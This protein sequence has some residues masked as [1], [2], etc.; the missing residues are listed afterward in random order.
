VLRTFL[1]SKFK[2][3]NSKFKIQKP[4][5]QLNKTT[6]PCLLLLWAV[7]SPGWASTAEVF[8]HID[9]AEA[10]EAAGEPRAAIIELKNAARLA[11]DD[12]DV[13]SRLGRL[14]LNTGQYAAAEKELS[15]AAALGIPAN[16]LGLARLALRRDDLDA[17]YTALREAIASDPDNARPWAMLGR[18]E[19]RRERRPQALSAYH[20][21]IELASRSGQLHLE[22][23]IIHLDDGRLA[24]A[25]GKAGDQAGLTDALLVALIAKGG[26]ASQSLLA[27]ANLAGSADQADQAD[28]SPRN[29]VI[30]AL[31]KR[32]PDDP[33]VID[34][35]GLAE[36]DDGHAGAALQRYQ[37][38]RQ[39]QPEQAVWWLRE[40]R[41][42]A[43]LKRGGQR[44]MLLI[45]ASKALPKSIPLR[46]A[47]ADAWIAAGRHAEARVVYQRLLEQTPGHAL[48]L[49][50][51]A[52][53]WLT[54]DPDKALDARRAVQA[55]PS[56]DNYYTLGI[57]LL[58]AESQARH[59]S[60][61]SGLHLDQVLA[62][63]KASARCGL[64][65][66]DLR[67]GSLVHHL[68]IDGV[69]EELYD[70]VAL[71]KVKN[72]LALGFKSDELRRLRCVGRMPMPMPGPMRCW[73]R[74]Y[75]TCRC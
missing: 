25:R 18:I 43:A 5:P 67:D 3:Q 32:H 10:F 49:Q 17:A 27:L 33:R 11:L 38:A 51:L 63:R 12:G 50:R 62:D 36:L 20:R 19:L 16:Q 60:T 39:Q 2:I 72:P 9:R 46:L 66:I 31:V 68:R 55:R 58:R 73:S 56:A 24:E 65:V 21:A 44:L 74:R 23:A 34:L 69:V 70:V 30:A 40:A 28:E 71:P 35:Q 14:Y 4:M 37:C 54:E 7:T 15:R 52:K 47:L 13:R 53:L 1:N 8:A 41:A 59:G 64:Q 75:A 45:Q 48:A 42:L 29:E 61:F 22:R 57:M 26:V 6:L